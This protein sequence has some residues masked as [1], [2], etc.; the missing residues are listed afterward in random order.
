MESGPW[1]G[2][3]DLA[4]G[5]VYTIT[6]P[7][8]ENNFTVKGED[9]SGG[10]ALI[11]NGESWVFGLGAKAASLEGELF[12]QL[13]FSVLSKQETDSFIFTLG[14]GVTLQDFHHYANLDSN[15][16]LY[17]DVDPDSWKTIERNYSNQV[18]LPS[19]SLGIHPRPTKL[20]TYALY[21]KWV[22]CPDITRKGAEYYW[23][24]LEARIRLNTSGPIRPIAG[25]T[26]LFNSIDS[27]S[28]GHQ[29][30]FGLEI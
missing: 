11:R 25:Y 15:S 20:F 7:S 24:P 5:S 27:D 18:F 13:N 10:A 14:F 3:T 29:F 1:T 6:A 28:P 23:L 21:A 19:L 17:D 12:H 2:T 9:F 16:S 22:P 4:K 26:L 8:K 30:Q